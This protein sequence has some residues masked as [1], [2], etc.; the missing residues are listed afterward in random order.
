MFQASCPSCASPVVFPH[1]DAL[2]TVC[3]ACNSMVVRTD[4]SVE[5]IGKVSAFD[6]DLSPIQLEASGVVGNRRFRVVGVVRL[7]RDRVRWN[8]WALQF[9][10]QGIGWLSESNGQTWLF[11]GEGEPAPAGAERARSVGDRFMKGTSTWVVVEAATARIVAA[12]GSLW[13]R[14]PANLEREYADLRRLGGGVGTLDREGEVPMLHA[15]EVVT[16]VGLRME[17]LRPV[18]GWDDPALTHFRGPEIAGV[19]RLDCP[20]CGATLEINAGSLT[21]RVVCAYCGAG[22][23]LDASGLSG[24]TG[25]DPRPPWKPALT[26]GHKGKLHGGEWQIVGA[27]ERSVTAEGVR[28]AWVEYFLYNPWRGGAWLVEANDHWSLVELLAEL[29]VMV[30]SS[31]TFRGHR[32]AAFQRGSARVDRV[33]GEFTW[34]VAVG[35]RVDTLDLVAPSESLMLSREVADGEETWALGLYIDRADV[36]AFCGHA[37]PEASGVAPHQPNPWSAAA[38]AKSLGLAAATFILAFLLGMGVYVAAA[39]ER[40]VVG[41]PELVAGEVALAD[42]V[43]PDVS[44]RDTELALAC[45]GGGEGAVVSLVHREEGHVYEESFTSGVGSGREWRLEPGAYTVRLQMEKSA[46]PATCKLTLTRDPPSL[47]ALVLGIL[48]AI[49]SAAV[50]L[51]MRSNFE[52]RRWANSDFS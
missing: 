27:M 47:T 20:S 33:A 26:L 15:G 43:V 50:P 21:S 2:T 5:S 28:Y 39:N 19:R 13:W 40:T 51:V 52:T 35:D 41:F 42:L 44:R 12:E 16:L 25:P 34:Q 22:S 17:G 23:E 49:A 30:H 4:R 8:E 9:E 14:A 46:A 18:T 10:D 7:A 11:E 45:L 32:F 1:A 3:A 6:R 24:T 48:A 38:I 36:E 37:L 29:P 31:A